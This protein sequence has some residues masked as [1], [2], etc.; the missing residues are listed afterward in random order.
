MLFTN[1]ACF[2]QY[3]E[4]CFLNFQIFALSK[5]QKCLYFLKIKP[6]NIW[7]DYI[8]GKRA[9]LMDVS[10]GYARIIII[11]IH[12]FPTF[13]TQRS[14]KT[15]MRAQVYHRESFWKKV[16]LLY[17]IVCKEKEKEAPKLVFQEWGERNQIEG[18]RDKGLISAEFDFRERVLKIA[19]RERGDWIETKS[20]NQYYGYISGIWREMRGGE[21]YELY[22]P[23]LNY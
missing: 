22:F 1:L 17:M 8:W 9:Y 14:K 18:E 7:S 5:Q 3:L 16:L 11:I 20:P 15:R 10:K 23:L 19:Q 4:K 12:E 2:H 6:N 13:Y 21:K